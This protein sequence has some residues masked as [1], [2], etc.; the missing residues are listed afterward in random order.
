MEIRKVETDFANSYIISDTDPEGRKVAVVIDPALELE[1]LLGLDVVLCLATHGH[2]DHINNAKKICDHFEIPLTLHE[3]EAIYV[4]DDSYNL[5]RY[6]L[7]RPLDKPE[8]LKLLSGG[9]E[10]SFLGH[11][12]KVYHTPGHT[13]GSVMYLLDARYLFSGDTLFKGTIGRTDLP[14]SSPEA[15]DATLTKLGEIAGDF[16]VFPGHGENTT[17]SRVQSQLEYLR[18]LL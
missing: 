1:E 4:K 15:M 6:V 12:I 3:K 18:G 5:S 8:N 2:A 17:F 9:D 14:G 16:E 10:L 7:H 13:Q 11:T